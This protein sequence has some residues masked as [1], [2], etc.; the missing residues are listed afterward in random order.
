MRGCALCVIW[1]TLYLEGYSSLTTSDDTTW[2][3]CGTLMTKIQSSE[4]QRVDL[5]GN[6]CASLS[7]P[8]RVSLHVLCESSE[9]AHLTKQ[10]HLVLLYGAVVGT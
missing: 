10:K 5:C 4:D 6:V 1:V 2:M 9:E 7:A 8:E 3:K